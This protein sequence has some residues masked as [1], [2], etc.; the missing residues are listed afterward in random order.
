[1][2]FKSSEALLIT[3]RPNIYHFSKIDV[4]GGVFLLLAKQK[5]FVFADARFIRG[6]AR[7]AHGFIPIATDKTDFSWWRQLLKRQEIK[8]VFFEP[9]DLTYYQLQKFRKI[10]RGLAELKPTK[11]D[12]RVLRSQK[13]QT[14]LAKIKKALSATEEIVGEIVKICRAGVFGKRK[15]SE[16]DLS[17]AIHHQAFLRGL[18][19]LAFAP[20]VAFG[21]NTGIPH[22]QPARTRQLKKGDMILLDLGV[23]YHNYCS[24]LT[25]VFFTASPTSRQA[26]VYQKVLLAQEAAL[27]K[28]KAGV[29]ASSLYDEVN[30]IFGTQI[31]H[32]T[33]GLGHGVGL[34]IHEHPSLKLESRDQL[35]NAQV[36][37]VEPGL[38]FSWGGVRIEDMVV[39][40]ENSAQNLTK[41]PKELEQVVIK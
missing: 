12:L 9:F 11:V 29:K 3:S 25:R 37:T 16:Y 19:H 22:H 40:R 28:I 30:K 4:S 6:A 33:H 35:S 5:K 26:E 38:Y 15:V 7:I 23:K 39:V 34:E 10:S 18:P 17:C 8:T 1:M 41:W 14:E 2:I 36:I 24:D 31:A 27:K 32:F 20:I 21:K 13:S